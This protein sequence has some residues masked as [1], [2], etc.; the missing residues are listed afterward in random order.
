M[1]KAFTLIELLIVIAIIA[2]LAAILFVS[3]G[4]KPLVKSRD[5]KRAA[6]LENLRTALALYY[7][8]KGFYPGTADLGA[9]LK[10]GS[11]IPELPK[12]PKDASGKVCPG[13]YTPNF[14]SATYLATQYG[15]SYSSVTS[16]NAACT[17]AA[18]NC[19]NY[20]VQACM[21]DGSPTTNQA[22]QADCDNLLA[23]PP[24]AADPIFDIHS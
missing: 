23:V 19:T 9:E 22:L 3:I 12:D 16:A 24:C 17:T 10:T 21:E 20:V 4:T 7:N 8:D 18:G 15:Y 14:P 13:T 6:D 5:A 2:I 1:K 11:Y